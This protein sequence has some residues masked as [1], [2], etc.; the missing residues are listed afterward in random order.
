MKVF[1]Y[2]WDE[3]SAGA[4]ALAKELGIK[5]IRHEGS[6]FKPR[7]WKT[8]INWG[9]GNTFPHWPL[10]NQCIILNK[11]IHVIDCQ[12]KLKF[13]QRVSNNQIGVDIPNPPR[14]P[15]WTTNVEIAKQWI[16]E[17]KKV[18]ARTILNGH[19]GSGI[20]IAETVDAVPPAP[21][22]VQYVPK[23][24]EYRVHIMKGEVIDVQRKIRDPDR[25]PSDWQVRSHANGFIFVRQ[26][27]NPPG[28]VIQN[29]AMAF[30]ASGLDFGAVDVIWN[31]KQ[32]KAYVLEINTAPGLEG[33]TVTKYA[34]AFRKILT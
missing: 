21:L 22:Y 4:K 8:V 19:S 13:F 14:I 25:E 10:N 24:S 31:D 23:S 12:N 27:V 17:K 9:A 30:A 15:E 16:S 29:A 28:D 20:I 5:R 11:P 1:L 6:K 18:V 7:S 32:Q 34:E 26:G 33:T 3:A 2:S